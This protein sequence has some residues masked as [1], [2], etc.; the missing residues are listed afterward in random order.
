MT[1]LFGVALGWVV[2]GQV[3]A[4]AAIVGWLPVE[5][6]IG[7]GAIYSLGAVVYATRRPDPLPRVF[8]YHEVFHAI[9]IG[10]SVCLYAH[11]VLVMRAVQ[12]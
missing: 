5:M 2:L 12:G 4:R 11:V 9:V 1:A 7:C 8:G 10:A 6:L 3:V